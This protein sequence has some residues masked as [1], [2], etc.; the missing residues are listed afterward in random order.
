MNYQ[1]LRDELANDPLTRGYATMSDAEAAADL[2]TA[3]R[4]TTA[5]IPSTELLAW[6][7]QNGRYTSIE[8]D[9]E[10]A[11]SSSQDIS[12]VAIKLIER[13]STSLDLSRT[14]HSQMLDALVS[15]G[16]LTSTDKNELQ[17]MSEKSISRTRELGLPE[18]SHYHVSRAR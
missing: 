15:N 5:P 7:G 10:N 8:G 14:D 2:N 9:S 6:A 12:K 11:T 16:V 13:D 18:I 1:T 4:T 17:S 3:Y